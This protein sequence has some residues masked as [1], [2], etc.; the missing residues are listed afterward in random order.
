MSCTFLLALLR[1]TLE[2]R[3]KSLAPSLTSH[4][5]LRLQ[6]LL[7]PPLQA[8]QHRHPDQRRLR[9]PVRHRGRVRLRRQGRALRAGD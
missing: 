7:Q 9:D 2:V 6:R 4:P 3:R 1:A 5:R 8:V